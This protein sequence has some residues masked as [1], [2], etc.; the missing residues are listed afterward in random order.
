LLRAIKYVLD[1]EFCALKI[2]PKRSNTLFYLEGVSDSHYAGDKDTRVSV[3][4]CIIYFCGAPIAWKSKSGKSVTLS[5]IE[6]EYFAL[7]EVSYVWQTSIRVNG[8]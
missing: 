1:T 3:F 8:Y 5:S 2:K 7:S 4:G 6:A